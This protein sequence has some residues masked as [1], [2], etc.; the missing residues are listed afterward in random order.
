MVRVIGKLVCWVVLIVF[1]GRM[2]CIGVSGSGELL[3]CSM[4]SIECILVSVVCVVLVVVV[5]VF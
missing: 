5:V 1:V 2:G 3:L 4:L